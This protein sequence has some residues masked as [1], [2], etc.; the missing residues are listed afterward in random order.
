MAMRN[1]RQA[2]RNREEIR[3]KKHQEK[4]Q[5]KLSRNASPEV[6]QE[7]PAGDINPDPKASP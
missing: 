3:K 4:L 7:A 1:Y 6:V 5:K 2:K